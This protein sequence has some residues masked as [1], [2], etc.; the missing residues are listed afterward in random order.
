MYLKDAF[1]YSNQDRLLTHTHQ[2]GLTGAPELLA[3]NTYNELGQLV[4]KKVGRTVASPLQKVDYSYNI[5]GWMTEINKVAGSTNPLQQGT[6][7]LDLFAFKIN[8][9]TV[10]NETNY[11]GKELYN[12]NISETYWRTS[13][14]NVLRKYGYFYDDLNRL[15]NAV[16]QKPGN[17]VAVTNSYNE[18]LSYDKNGNILALQRKG[19]YEDNAL[20]L[21]TDNLN[22]FYNF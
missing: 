20:Q 21:Q 10:Q 22:Y 1:T 19:E 15:K 3:D 12:G 11:T 13:S 9:N 6:D 17:S 18:S 16:Y 4:S 5:R 14:D 7:P 8:Y 2:I